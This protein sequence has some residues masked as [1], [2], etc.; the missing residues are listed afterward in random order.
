MR[1]FMVKGRSCGG[2]KHTNATRTDG[3]E[4]RLALLHFHVVTQPASI[5]FK[6]KEY[7]SRHYEL[8]PNLKHFQSVLEFHTPNW[9]YTILDTEGALDYLSGSSDQRKRASFL[10]L[11]QVVLVSFSSE[12][13]VGVHK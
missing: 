8:A 2:W 10:I 9:K 6:S 11:K 5:Q 1:F 7:T 12:F 4:R 3:D 13:L